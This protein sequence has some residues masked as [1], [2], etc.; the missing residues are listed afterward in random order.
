MTW[1]STWLWWF[2]AKITGDSIVASKSLPQDSHLTR[3]AIFTMRSTSNMQKR[4]HRNAGE[5]NCFR[6]ASAIGGDLALCSW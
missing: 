2:D 3:H 6:I 4:Q 1:V 5:R